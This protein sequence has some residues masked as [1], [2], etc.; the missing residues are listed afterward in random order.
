MEETKNTAAIVLAAGKGTRIGQHL[1][2]AL[3]P[4]VGKPMLYYCLDLVKKIPVQNVYVVV[5]Y[6]A[7]DVK[8]SI[9]NEKINYVYQEEQLGTAHAVE[10]ALD[11][12]PEDVREV[13]VFNGDDSAFFEVSTIRQFIKSHRDSLAKLSF[14]STVVD[15]PS[16]LGRVVREE[17]K[18]V[19]IVEE[20]FASDQ[21]KLINEV[22][23]GCYIFDKKW[24]Q[25]GIDR[26][27]K[28]TS[29]EYYITDLVS[30]ALKEK[31]EVNDFLLENKD[32]WRGI[33]NQEEL[34]EA[35]EKMLLK[36]V[37]QKEPTVF[38][39]DIDNTLIDTD[40]IKKFVSDNLVK[41]LIKPDLLKVFWEE[42]D[43]SRDRLGYVSI[44]EFSDS[45]AERVRRPEFSEE[46]RKMFYTI[47]FNEFV[48][49]GVNDLMEYIDPKGEIV[50]LT[51]G[52]LVYQ[53]MKIKNLK[54]SKYLD[55][56]F[57]FETL[58]HG[59][60]DV[61]VI[62][63][64]YGGRRKI[65]I[66]DKITNLESIKNGVKNSI[67]IHIKQGMYKDLVPKDPNF[68]AD[69]VAQNI[70]EVTNFVRTLY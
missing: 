13:I 4:I 45:F 7:T 16:G 33:N 53:P 54:I 8:G 17:D 57:V 55:E 2:K 37:K 30:I 19:E 50:I 21:Q 32:E 39:F 36:F 67:V 64:I 69:F 12:L 43:L 11:K 28:N 40:T 46:V 62:D 24:L 6:K 26:V 34:K 1:P 68:K 15:V 49:D 5:G 20:K 52:D 27:S 25:S 35:N 63:K 9:R 65:V 38:I 60:E 66:D 31:I 23:V 10:L 22:N 48:S 58:F 18:V 47:P 61:E 56:M 41:K 42:Y 51:D 70:F 14:M 29:G 59:L 44:P 3:Y